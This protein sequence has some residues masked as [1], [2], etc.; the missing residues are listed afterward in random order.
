M[1]GAK[2]RT[3]DQLFA[4]R[5]FGAVHNPHIQKSMLYSQQ[6]RG[7]YTSSFTLHA[8]WTDFRRTPGLEIPWAA[9]NLS[10]SIRMRTTCSRVLIKTY[11][12]LSETY[13]PTDA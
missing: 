5:F 10:H 13:V 4:F 1:R 11:E 9:M 12:E 8:K 2:M 6:Y 3:I 7:F